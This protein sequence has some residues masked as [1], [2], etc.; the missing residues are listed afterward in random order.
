MTYM[1]HDQEKLIVYVQ[2]QAAL[3]RS[4]QISLDQLSARVT[5]LNF[6]ERFTEEVQQAN[7][8]LDHLISDIAPDLEWQPG[9]EL[10]ERFLKLVDGLSV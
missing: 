6:D 4:G 3:F 1:K 9:G 5:H 10:V 8:M 2:A 7:P